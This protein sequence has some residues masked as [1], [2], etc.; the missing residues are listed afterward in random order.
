MTQLSR[1]YQVLV[2]SWASSNYSKCLTP[3]DVTS[4][5]PRF[6]EMLQELLIGRS[7]NDD[8]GG[9]GISSANSRAR[10]PSTRSTRSLSSASFIVLPFS[11]RT[12]ASLIVA[13][14]SRAAIRVTA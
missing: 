4:S 9:T 14:V 7:R 5:N 10:P 13:L 8:G 11:E 1:K 6:G 12:H 3:T 2:A